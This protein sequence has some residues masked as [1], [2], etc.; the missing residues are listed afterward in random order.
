MRKYTYSKPNKDQK[1]NLVIKK[2]LILSEIADKDDF[3][4]KWRDRREE[5]LLERCQ[6]LAQV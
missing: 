6:D 2:L 4:G 5:E 1:V 3:G